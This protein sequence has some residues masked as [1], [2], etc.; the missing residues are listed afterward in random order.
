MAINVR[1]RPLICFHEACIDV[2]RNRFEK[3]DINRLLTLIDSRVDLKDV[4]RK[5]IKSYA[6]KKTF[7]GQS[8]FRRIVA[9]LPAP[10][11]ENSLET[12][13]PEVAK[14]WHPEKNSPLSPA[15][16]SPMSGYKVWWQ[17]D[18]EQ[19][20]VW[21]TAISGRTANGADCPYCAG[22]LPSSKHNLEKSFPEVAKYFH[23]K[24]NGNKK[25]KDFTPKSNKKVWWACAEC[26]VAFERAIITRIKSP[27]CRGCSY[28]ARAIKRKE[29]LDEK[30]KI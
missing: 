29:T 13:F 27:L 11:V 18:R 25:P 20:H 14:Q 7:A 1:E 24:L 10:L 2:N 3:R 19:S 8:E 6:A 28:K 22:N 26:N 5:R 12:N 17:C 9:A 23:P 4:E 15:N 21:K 30:S 16:F